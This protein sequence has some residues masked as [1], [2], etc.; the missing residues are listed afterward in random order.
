M[1]LSVIIVNYN[2]RAFLEQCLYSLQRALSGLEAEVLVADNASTDGSVQKLKPA[3]PWVN[4]LENTDNLGFAKANNQALAHASGAYILF[5]NP[6]TLLPE[7]ALRTCIRFLD[8]TPE[9][10]AAGVKMYDGGGNYLPESKRGNPGLF[11]SLCKLAGL[12]H[13]FP[14]SKWLARYYMGHLSSAQNHPVEVLAGAFMMVR[15]EVLDITGGFD[16]RFF[17]YGE[18]ID[19]SYRINQ[20]LRPGTQKHWQTWYLA[21]VS[22]IH[23][24]G[25]STRRGSLNYVLLFYKAMMQFVQKHYASGPASMFRIFIFSAIGLRAVAAGMVRVLRR[26]AD[27]LFAWAQKTTSRLEVSNLPCIACE[28]V[29]VA[30]DNADVQMVHQILMA[31]RVKVDKVALV[32]DYE[33]FC[34]TKQEREVIVFCPDD[35]RPLASFVQMM[36][37]FKPGAVYF[38]YPASSSVVGSSNKEKA[39]EVF[40]LP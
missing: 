21:Q 30:G 32:A 10:G 27:W 12:H 5:L 7:D 24:K 28:K 36:L 40:S 23:F 15:R 22:I 1:K 18:D 4:W 31:N 39:G 37:H 14:H 19:L 34:R 38:H 3:F 35:E 29:W 13:I 33:A 8:N 25:E 17:M 26:T 16:E 9:A 11:T 2:V 6:D 20:T